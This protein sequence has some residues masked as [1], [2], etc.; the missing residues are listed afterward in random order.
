MQAEA[1]TG[2]PSM[3]YTRHICAALD[4][5][6]SQVKYWLDSGLLPSRSLSP[7]PG[8]SRFTTP[9]DLILFAVSIG[10]EPKWG[11]VLEID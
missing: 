10:L 8:R 7:E 9:A 3:L 5:K 2:I 1:P 11:E 6:P 4:V